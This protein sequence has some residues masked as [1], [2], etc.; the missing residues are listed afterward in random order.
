MPALKSQPNF[1]WLPSDDDRGGS[2]D[3][4]DDGPEPGR[5]TTIQLTGFK[6]KVN[7]RKPMVSPAYTFTLL[8]KPHNANK[9]CKEQH[10]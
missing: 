4:S 8:W 10:M 5:L 3:G 6:T 9:L 2:D 1:S 7:K